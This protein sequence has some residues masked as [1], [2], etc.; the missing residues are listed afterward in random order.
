M[1][2]AAFD[3]I[4]YQFSD[5]ESRSQQQNHLVDADSDLLAQQDD[6]GKRAL[7][8]PS[9]CE[10]EMLRRIRDVA[11]SLIGF[12]HRALPLRYCLRTRHVQ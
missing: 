5:R 11:I 2:G 7:Q 8:D 3:Q 9:L 6:F 12:I 1:F 4:L 10:A